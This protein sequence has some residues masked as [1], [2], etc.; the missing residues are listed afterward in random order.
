MGKTVADLLD[1]GIRW[2]QYRDKE[3]CR[4]DVYRTGLRLREICRA[5]QALLIV[6]DYPD[7]AMA[8][9]AD[10]VHLGQEDLPI[11]E[12]KKVM[13]GK[14]IGISTHSV[15]EAEAAE[16]D[17]ADYIGFG[18][19]FPTSTKDAGE[20]QGLTALG[21]IVRAVRIP[22]IAIGGIT[23][24]DAE[25]VFASGCAGIAAA[26]GFLSGHPRE[27]ARRYLLSVPSRLSQ[28]SV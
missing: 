11:K 9:D 4:A 8:I 22:V 23:P 24:A 14:I 2:I 6:N 27:N 5:C 10:G 19:V 7:V 1:E 26:S 15:K 25:A 18:P 12:A 17:G 28:R 21:E 13:R 16:R 20:P 3:R